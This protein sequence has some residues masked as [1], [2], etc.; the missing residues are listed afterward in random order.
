M[1]DF[2]IDIDTNNI[3]S[4]IAYS[5]VEGDSNDKNNWK[6]KLEDVTKFVQSSTEYGANKEGY[7][8]FEKDKKLK[9]QKVTK[10]GLDPLVFIVVSLGVILATSVAI[11]VLKPKKA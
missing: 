3:S 8:F 9:G 2:D 1:T 5:K 7:G 6:Q 10:M 4:E 11:I